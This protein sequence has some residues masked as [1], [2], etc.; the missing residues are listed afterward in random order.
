MRIRTA[1]FAAFA[2]CVTT[3]LAAATYTVMNTNDAGVGSLRQAI[4]DANGNVGADTIAFSMVGSGVHTIAPTSQLPT[5]TDA[6]TIDGYTQP[7]AL[8]N[9][10]PPG[11]G[12]NA[13]LLIEI[14][15]TNAS[16]EGVLKT[17]GP[18]NSNVTIRGLVI[19]RSPGVA[20][21]IYGQ[22]SNFAV[23][24]CFLGTDPTGLTTID[25]DNVEGVLIDISAMNVRIGGSTPAARNVISGNAS[26]QIAFGCNSSAGGTGH[27]IQGNLIGPDATGA[28]VPPHNF[29]GQ[30]NGLNL[31]YGVSGVTVGGATAAERNVISGNVGV[32]V[33]LASSFSN[34]V[35]DNTIR[36]NY[37][38]T[39][40]TGSARLGNGAGIQINQGNNNV[41]DNVISANGGEGISVSGSNV[42][43]QGNKIGTDAGGTAA[44]GNA[45]IGVHAYNASAT[46]GGTGAGEPNVIAYNG[47]NSSNGHGV[48]IEG[49]TTGNAVR[50]N[51]I[52][53]NV[54]LGISFGGGT[55]T[56]ND[57]GDA[58][59]G[60]NGL[61]N[62]P[63][64]STL[65][66]AAVETPEAGLR[67]QG[68]L[69][70]TTFSPI[71]PA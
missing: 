25:R 10:N 33:N 19:N 56:P 37:I 43:I 21:I 3:R 6:V 47:T 15:G 68:V 52:H 64:L 9:T 28:A 45:G 18:S 55:P 17:Q 8:A 49:N 70:S 13:V 57:P 39:D 67:I 69:H 16:F 30:N 26:T 22:G 12:T 29:A 63:V 4:L 20:I 34:D 46:I 11:Q 44:L 48:R 71:P 38:G 5:I 41:F 14:D 31:C 65:T 32:G 7:G 66:P 23:E 54:G 58:D 35:H 24:G 62:Y 53:D 61:Q 60:P 59:T 51:S 40:V 1:V 27:L 50:A 42:P 36:G 2:L